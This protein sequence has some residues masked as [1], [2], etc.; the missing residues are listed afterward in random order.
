MSYVRLRLPL[1]VELLSQD[2][3][4]SAPSQKPLYRAAPMAQVVDAP[5]R[6]V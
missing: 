2:W 4:W 1:P 5:L 3:R 6:I